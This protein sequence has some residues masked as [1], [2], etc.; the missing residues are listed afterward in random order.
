MAG[1]NEFKTGGQTRKTDY[2]VKTAIKDCPVQYFC[3]AW[4][5][6]GV[7]LLVLLQKADERM[8]SIDLLQ[9]Y[10]ILNAA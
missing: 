6:Q 10:E 1:G 5:R 3:S 7:D 4:M 8:E 2:R 9:Y